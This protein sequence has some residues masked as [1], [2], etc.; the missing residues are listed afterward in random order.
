MGRLTAGAADGTR[1]VI[2]DTGIG[3]KDVISI[4]G[5]N[6]AVYRKEQAH[7]E[8]DILIA[9]YLKDILGLEALSAVSPKNA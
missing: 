4:D 7:T 5:L 8:T 9:G 6:L 3:D 2:P 1:A